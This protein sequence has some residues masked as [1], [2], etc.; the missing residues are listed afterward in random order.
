M[1][2]SRFQRD[3]KDTKVSKRPKQFHPSSTQPQIYE[4]GLQGLI[5]RQGR[6]ISSFQVTA[7][8]LEKVYQTQQLSAI[9]GVILFSIS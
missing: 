9:C 7:K 4:E 3:P 1:G 5:M 6:K 2:P 8:S